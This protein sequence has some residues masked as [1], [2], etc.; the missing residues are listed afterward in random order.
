M[1]G[2]LAVVATVLVAMIKTTAHP[3]R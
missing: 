3:N 2:F 1:S